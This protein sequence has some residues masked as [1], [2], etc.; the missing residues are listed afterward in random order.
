[1]RAVMKILL[2][3]VVIIVIIVIICAMLQI[4]RY[5]GL[6][7]RERLFLLDREYDRKPRASDS[8]VV[9]TMST[10]PDRIRLIGPTLASL[11]DQSVRVDEIAINVPLVSRKGL[12]Y[13]IPSWLKRL[14][15]VKI[16]RVKKDLGPGTKVFDTLRRESPGTRVIAVDDDNIYNSNTIAVLVNSFEHHLKRGEMV[17][18]TNYG[19][20]LQRDGSLPTMT[21]RISV[22]LQNEH[23]TDLLQGFSGF[24]VDP[25]MFDDS[26]HHLE[27]GPEE[28]I[29]VDD[30]WLSGWL[31]LNGYRIMTSKFIY[32]HLPIINFG[33]MRLTPALASGE[34]KD[35]VTDQKVIDWFIDRGFPYVRQPRHEH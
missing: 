18:V 23:E 10:I 20:T 21:E 29:S 31:K 12:E 24:I 25:V 9:I 17:A 11:L 22:V 3:V 5:G 32:R 16:H 6:K 13:S 27:D 35:F 1:M 28:A 33:E 2:I 30:V 19:V 34:N 4:G 26:I 8:R 14:R 15:H 7:C